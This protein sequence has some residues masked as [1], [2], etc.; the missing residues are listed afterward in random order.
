M[1]KG[2]GSASAPALEPLK[3]PLQTPGSASQ[4]TV[5]EQQLRR[6]LAAT[7]SRPM[8]GGST[9]TSPTAG[10]ATKLGGD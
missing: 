4:A 2:G 9:V 6:G 5:R 3:S 7:F 8:F 1:G 10:K